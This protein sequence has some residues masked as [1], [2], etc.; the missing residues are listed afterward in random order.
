[1][2]FSSLPGWFW[3]IY[4][5][6]LLIAFSL[7]CVYFS[8]KKKQRTSMIGSIINICCILFVP[9]FSALNSIAREGNEWDHFKLSFS[10]GESWT[11]YTL[12]GHIYILVWTLLLI[13]LL[14]CLFKRKI[15]KS[16]VKE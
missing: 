15:M 13:W 10:Q 14:F 1:M 7:S 5:G 9:V 4:Y 12:G 6:C 8:Q 2:I 16:S 3:A 11:F